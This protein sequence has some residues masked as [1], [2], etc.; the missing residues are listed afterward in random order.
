MPMNRTFG[1]MKWLLLG[2]ILLVN[3]PSSQD[4][5]APGA[6]AGKF[7]LTSTAFEN[8]ATIPVQYGC[9]GSDTS[10]A[11]SWTDPPAGSKSFA[12]I[13][14]DPDA[15]SGTWV[16]WVLF[17]L[18]ASTRQLPEDMPKKAELDGGARHGRNDFRRLGYGGP[19]PPPGPAHRY[20]FKLYALDAKVGLKPGATK[21]DLENAMKGHILAE[22]QIVGRYG[23]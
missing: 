1:L 8:G 11:L 22:A 23:R 4:A 3:A 17:D 15:P 14:D 19:C 10:P 5:A 13:A 9:A 16:H 20:F 21:A 6:P 18:P 2:A 7:R 12:L